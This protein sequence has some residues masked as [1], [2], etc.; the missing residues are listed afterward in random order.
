MNLTHGK[1]ENIMKPGKYLEL[2]DNDDAKLV[3]CS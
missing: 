1:E 3:G 2:S